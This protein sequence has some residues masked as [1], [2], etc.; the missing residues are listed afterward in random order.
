MLQ[1][2]ERPPATE[3]ELEIQLNYIERLIGSLTPTDDLTVAVLEQQKSILELLREAGDPGQARQNELLRRF[4]EGAEVTTNLPV[5]RVGTAATTIPNGQQGIAIFE[6]WSGEF[7]ALVT[8]ERDI[9]VDQEIV[10]SGESNLVRPAPDVERI[11]DV[12]GPEAGTTRPQD[13]VQVTNETWVNEKE[14]VDP[15]VSFID[16][17]DPLGPGEDTTVYEVRSTSRAVELFAKASGATTHFA[18]LDGDGNDES[19][20]EYVFEYQRGP[21]DDWERHRGLSDLTALGTLTRPAE[22]EPGRLIG[23]VFGW[24]LRFV[25]RTDDSSLTDTDVA[26]DQLGGRF[27]GEVNVVA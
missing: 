22:L 11:R 17:P 7:Q 19:V 18:D 3:E 8:A 2:Q 26:E 13:L 20:V 15:T 12:G 21:G 5:G 6:G 10:V 23:P 14:A 4:V 9:E 27:V 25:N 24:R 16:L 1:Q